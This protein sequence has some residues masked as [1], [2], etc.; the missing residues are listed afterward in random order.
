MPA[1]CKTVVLALCS[2]V[3]GFGVRFNPLVLR[4]GVGSELAVGTKVLEF[5]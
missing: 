2:V 3:S 4:R 1:S 5:C